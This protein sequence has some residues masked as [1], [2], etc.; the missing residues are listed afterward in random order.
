MSSKETCIFTLYI[1]ALFSVNALFGLRT[2]FFA[3]S[4]KPRHVKINNDETYD[5]YCAFFTP[6]YA[7]ASGMYTLVVLSAL[8]DMCDRQLPQA[9]T[10]FMRKSDQ[11]F[12]GYTSA[13]GICDSIEEKLKFFKAYGSDNHEV[14]DCPPVF[15]HLL[16]GE[17]KLL[18]C[19]ATRVLIFV[20]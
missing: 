14:G 9:L 6:N 15:V 1:F 4:E 8:T 12:T 17:M 5:M 18:L 2:L 3:D 19:C 20:K 11:S 10:A 13:A 16:L 7:F